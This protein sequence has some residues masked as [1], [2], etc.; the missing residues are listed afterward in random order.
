MSVGLRGESRKITQ[1]IMVADFY[2]LAINRFCN[3]R[4]F[5]EFRIMQA[6]CQKNRRA[7]FDS[8]Y[9]KHQAIRL[10]MTV[11]VFMDGADRQTEYEYD[12]VVI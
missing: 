7:A 6:V 8:M 4:E 5:D 1:K 10:Q 12:K 2:G 9:N 11:P 3:E